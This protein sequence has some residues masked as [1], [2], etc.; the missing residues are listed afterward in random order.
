MKKGTKNE[1][2]ERAARSFVRESVHLELLLRIFLFI[3]SR[4]LHSFDSPS[5]S[6]HPSFTFSHAAI[7]SA[8]A[9]AAGPAFLPP[10]T[11]TTSTSKV[12]T[13]ASPAVFSLESSGYKEE[14]K[15]E[16]PDLIH[17]LSSFGNNLPFQ[18][19]PYPN[20]P[21]MLSEQNIVPLGP[22]NPTRI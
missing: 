10:R 2:N 8:A 6:L 5:S 7:T 15:K 20:R 1:K 21:E 9:T 16:T 14:K 17:L 22:P 19:P 12:D 13:S 11:R 18:P 4:S 3:Y